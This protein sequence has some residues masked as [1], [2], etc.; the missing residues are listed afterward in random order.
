M[1]QMI[2]WFDCM[3]YHVF[4]C[5]Y[6]EFHTFTEVPSVLLSQRVRVPHLVHADD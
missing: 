3:F 4:H 1:I 5:F 2:T 6:I